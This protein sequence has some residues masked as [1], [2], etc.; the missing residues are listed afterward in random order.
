MSKVIVLPV[1]V[2]FGDCDPAGIV[3]FPNFFRWYDAASRNFFHACGVPAWR[4]TEKRNGIIGTPVVDIS[5]RF[6]KTA[7]YGERIE[8]HTSV[9]EWNA[10]TFVMQHQ[11]M[12]AGELLA[13]GRDTRVFAIRH[14][15]DPERI[16]AVPIPEEIRNLCR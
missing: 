9:I 2:E 12:R 14:P 13:E 5:S 11:I 16:K 15:D 7:T 10:K 3:F 1:S 8:V 4:D 6:V